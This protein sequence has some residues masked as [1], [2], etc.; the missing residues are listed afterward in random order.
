[1]IPMKYGMKFQGGATRARPAFRSLLCG[2]IFATSLFP[3]ASVLRAD[4]ILEEMPWYDTRAAEVKSVPLDSFESSNAEHRNTDWVHTPQTASGGSF[5][6]WFDWFDWS[7]SGNLNPGT[8][9]PT[10][11]RIINVILWLLVGFICLALLIWVAWLLMKQEW[12]R[13]DSE[14]ETDWLQGPKIDPARF[15]ALPFEVQ[16]PQSDLLSLARQAQSE[17]KNREAMIYLYS[18]MLLM[19]DQKHLIHLAKGKT[20]RTY[21]RELRG[22]KAIHKLLEKVV[23]SFE[24]VFFGNLVLDPDEFQDRWGEVSRFHELIGIQKA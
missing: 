12:R 20:N 19:L 15:E 23:V 24:D 10:F 9:N 6:D 11:G 8:M 17:G 22:Q 21:L 2:V 3:A 1:M 7:G 13:R 14:D 16:V 18:Y 5:W 4:D